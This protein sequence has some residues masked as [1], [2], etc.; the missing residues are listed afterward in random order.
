[1]FRIF[2]RLSSQFSSHALTK[3]KIF[4]YMSI[5]VSNDISLIKSAEFEYIGKSNLVSYAIWEP[6]FQSIFFSSGDWL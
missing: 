2:P 4:L 3:M 5:F 1:M 6:L